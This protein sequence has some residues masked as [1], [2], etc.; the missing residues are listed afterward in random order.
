MAGESTIS[1]TDATWNPVRGCT[2]VSEGCRNC[3]AERIAARFT[4]PGQPFHGF[5]KV[6]APRDGLDRV[7]GRRNGWTGRVE[8]VPDQLDW[9]LS[10]RGSAQ[11]R[12]EG[13]RSRVF[14]NSMSDLFHES[15]PDHDIIAVLGAIAASPQHTFQVLTKR[16]DR[17]ARFFL[18]PNLA[19]RVEDARVS[20]YRRH[21]NRHPG[22]A[23]PEHLFGG[24]V[25]NRWPLRNL[26][27]GTSVE[28]QRTADYRVPQLLSITDAVVHFV[29]YEPALG[30]VGFR[31]LDD[32]SDLGHGA[33]WFS[34]SQH[35]RASLRWVIVGGESGPCARPF[36][37]KWALRV[38]QLCQQFS[39]PFFFKQLG[40]Y[41]VLSAPEHG[42]PSGRIFEGDSNGVRV[43]LADR[44]GEDWTEWPENYRVREFPG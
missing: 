43:R 28:D 5:A 14:V 16:P 42:W 32:F 13:R 1:W 24:D 6:V 34:P 40:A 2:R 44:K 39:V 20:A 35:G 30:P 7:G 8:L 37:V 22:K 27:L 15:L 4:K 11:A 31:P 33:G 9:P 23:V 21:Y 18:L 12:A 41:P 29:S 3:Y 25:R 38:K 10:W 19:S 17:M 26:W 36:V